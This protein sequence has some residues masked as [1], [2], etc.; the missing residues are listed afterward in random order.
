MVE[1]SVAFGPVQGTPSSSTW[2]WHDELLSVHWVFGASWFPTISARSERL[3]YRQLREQGVRWV[4]S[5]GTQTRLIGAVAPAQN[6]NMTGQCA[7]AAVAFALSHPHGAHAHCLEVPHQGF[8]LVASSDGRLLSQTDCWLE[9]DSQVL[10]TLGMLRERHPDLQFVQQRWAANSDTASADAAERPAFLNNESGS[11]RFRKT[12]NRPRLWLVLILALA[13]TFSLAFVWVFGASK[14]NKI[15]SRYLEQQA[16]QALPSVL[17]HTPSALDAVLRAWHE[18]PVDPAGWLLQHVH[19]R[20]SRDQAI[21]QARYKRRKL[22]ADNDG[23]ERHRPTGWMF[24][25]DSVDH[26]YLSRT[27]ALPRIALQPSR[28]M[29]VEQGLVQLQHLSAQAASLSL[30]AVIDSG[31][32]TSSVTTHSE[33]QSMGGSTVRRTV[34]LQVALRQAPVLKRLTLPIEW[35]E[36]S[37]EIHQ[38]AHV[39]E[40][41]GYLMMSL[42]GEWIELL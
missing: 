2:C 13:V 21:C 32:S 41:H 40:R 20:V 11:C 30:G 23:L 6:S 7:S 8:W 9:D 3:L 29:S 24:K 35:H 18:L 5:H 25:A 15:D 27:F 22:Q 34:S 14:H 10:Q 37:L 4:A 36:V 17:V 12:A 16:I 19:C 28:R 31:Y 26:A 33:T 39:D 38:G 42:K 1:Q